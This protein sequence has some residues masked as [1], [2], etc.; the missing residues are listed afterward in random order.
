MSLEVAQISIMM[1]DDQ[2]SLILQSCW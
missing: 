2:D 1:W